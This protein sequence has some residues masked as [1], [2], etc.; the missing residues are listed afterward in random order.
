[1]SQPLLDAALVPDRRQSAV[2]ADIVD[3]ARGLRLPFYNVPVS[4]LVS[5]PHAPIERRHGAYYIRLMVIDRPG[6][7]AEVSAIL[8]DEDISVESLLQRGRDPEEVVPLVMTTHEADEDAMLRALERFGD[9][10][11]VSE[12][13][14][15]IR[16]EDL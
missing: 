9:L 2:V 1:M 15:T 7:I 11:A 4:D 12:T 5:T 14:L 8:R 3:I 16:I 10:D 13:P 6:V